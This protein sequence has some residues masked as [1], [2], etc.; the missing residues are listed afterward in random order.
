METVTEENS[1]PFDSLGIQSSVL[2]ENIRRL[3]FS[4]AT[5]IQGEVIP[6]A[7]EKRD[8]S[9]LSRT[10]TGKTCA[11]LIPLIDRLLSLPETSLSLCLAPTRE[12]ALQI[13]AEASK[14]CAGLP[15]RAVSTV[16]G[17]PI[18]EQIQEMRDGARII[19]GTPGR[20]MDLMRNR[21]F[22]PK[23]VEVLVFDEADRMFDM[24]FIDDMRVILERVN[25]QRQILLF[26]ATMN[27]SVLN[28][29]YEFKCD[30][31]EIN[32][33]KDR[34]TAE[35]IDQI[36]YQVS[37]REK[38]AYLVKFCKEAAEG[39]IIIFV[40]YREKVHQVADLLVAN[41][42]QATGISSLLRQDKRNKI[43]ASF[44]KG[45]FRALVA[46]DVASRGID[47][48]DVA[49]VVN[50]QLPDEAANYVHRIG[51]TARAGK[52][53][54]AI[55][56][57]GP[58]D[59]YNQ[60]KIE[61]FIGAKIPVGWLQPSEIDLNI[62]VPGRPVRRPP[63]Q[64]R[65]EPSRHPSRRD[66]MP[67]VL[68]ENE[69]TNMNEQTP[70]DSVLPMKTDA[71]IVEPRMPSREREQRPP[72]RS[73]PR[74]ANPRANDRPEPRGPRPPRDDRPMRH[75]RPM[76]DTPPGANEDRPQRGDRPM[77]DGHRGRN[78]RGPR[79]DFRRNGPDGPRRNDNRAPLAEQ[80]VTA[81]ALQS[82]IT[83]NPAIYCTKTGK[84]KAG[85]A[86]ASRTSAMNESAERKVNFLQKI[87]STVSSIFSKK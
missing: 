60:L 79:N 55:S 84:L 5:Q 87:G 23:C 10:G 36:I 68:A 41:G 39:G 45:G 17:M 85:S 62:D 63:T 38:P 73:A 7:L 77:R 9:G 54:K 18:H 29:M 72:M 81:A 47:V 19:I 12:L 27:F 74:A 46:T 35:G 21:A 56:I 70:D 30:P 78:D 6:L 25:P 32:V 65:V 2:L 53:G 43:I 59:G 83:G 8:V 57:A 3:G 50:Y 58:E 44:R 69:E 14:L 20:V 34:I 1:I 75:D 4:N 24:G 22:D 61:E 28:M 66:P 13:E 42:I 67:A 52:S 80:G 71:P 82:P 26:S 16:G 37:N 40:N 15:I 51:R 64:E 76:R 49:L 31:V 33:S 11:F 86:S 48:D